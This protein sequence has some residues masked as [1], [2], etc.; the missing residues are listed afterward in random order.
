MKIKL[1]SAFGLPEKAPIIAVLAVFS[2]LMGLGMTAD[3]IAGENRQWIGLILLAAAFGVYLFF[4]YKS[5]NLT[6]KP[7]PVD[8]NK[9]YLISIIP[10]N[11]SLLN[12]IKK[13][14]PNLQKIYFIHDNFSNDKVNEVKKEIKNDKSLYSQAKYLKVKSIQEPKNIISSFDDIL[15]ELK[16]D[17][18]ENDDILVEVTSGQTLASLTLYHLS[19]L[20]KIDVACLVSKYD[21]SNQ[22]IDNSTV[23]T[24][25]KFDLKTV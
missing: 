16:N 3:L 22:V 9:K 14:Y 19:I 15:D 8:T 1:L 2:A 12:S 18:A 7:S 5:R 25:I 13:Y 17:S 24:T 10:S 21:E 11:M 6:F 23:P 20:Y 4:N